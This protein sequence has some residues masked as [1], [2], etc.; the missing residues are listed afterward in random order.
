METSVSEPYV[1]YESGSRIFLVLKLSWIRIQEKKPFFLDNEKQVG[2]PCKVIWFYP[3]GGSGPCWIRIHISNK[4][5]DP[6][7]EFE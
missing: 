6:S 4:D 3:A 5:P 2:T 1:Y 7:G